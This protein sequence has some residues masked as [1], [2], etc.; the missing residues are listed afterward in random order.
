MGRSAFAHKGGLHVA[1]VEHA[2]QTFEHVDPASVGNEQRIVVSEL[3]GKGAV[4]RKAHDMGLE[5]EGDDARVAVDPK[6]LKD[7][8]HRGYHY[9]AAD[10]SLRAAAARGSWRRTSRSSASRA[11]A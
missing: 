10:A 8:E 1:A 6:R 5:L 7:R 2:P 4:L 3:S 9:E 11:S